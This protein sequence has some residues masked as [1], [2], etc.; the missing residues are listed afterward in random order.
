MMDTDVAKPL[1]IV[2]VYF[3]TTATTKPPAAANRTNIKAQ[4]LFEVMLYS[5]ITESAHSVCLAKRGLRHK[6]F[7]HD[8]EGSRA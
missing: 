8:N 6:I 1:M 7:I 4:T 2:L 5:E 3:T